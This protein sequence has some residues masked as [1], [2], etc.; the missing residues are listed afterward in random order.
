MVSEELHEASKEDPDCKK[1]DAHNDVFGQ[2]RIVIPDGLEE[3]QHSY[4]PSTV[5]QKEALHTFTQSVVPLLSE[6][7]SFYPGDGSVFAIS[8]RN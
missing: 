1:C 2:L 6:I 5:H 4:R 8:L 3:S 7:F